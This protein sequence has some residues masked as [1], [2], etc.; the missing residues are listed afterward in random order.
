MS[1]SAL[2]RGYSNARDGANMQN[3]VLTAATT[4]SRGDKR[5]FWSL[6][7]NGVATYVA[8]SAEVASAQSPPRRN[9]RH[10]VPVGWCARRC[11]RSG[12]R[13]TS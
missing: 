10:D 4:R 8:C 12:L 6:G 7:V 3:S 1:V 11:L 9:A 5:L 13:C 2:T